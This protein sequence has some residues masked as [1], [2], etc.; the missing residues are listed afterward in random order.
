MSTDENSRFERELNWSLG[1]DLRLN[2]TAQQKLDLIIAQAAARVAEQ[3]WRLEEA[4]S[5]VMRLSEQIRTQADHDSASSLTE[6]HVAFAMSA[7][8]PCWPIC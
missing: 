1:S 4:R 5:V 8:C 3:P 7:L 6:T 2:V